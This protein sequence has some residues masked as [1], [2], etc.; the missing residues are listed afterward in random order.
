MVGLG[1]GGGGSAS[2]AVGSASLGGTAVKDRRG[3]IGEGAPS[4]PDILLQ[5]AKG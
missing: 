3:R 2:L 5:L 4:S 1:I